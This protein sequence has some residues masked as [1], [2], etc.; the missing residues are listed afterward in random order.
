MS[1]LT[2]CLQTET[3]KALVLPGELVQPPDPVEWA[4]DMFAASLPEADMQSKDVGAGK[5]LAK[6]SYFD[7]QDPASFERFKHRILN[8]LPVHGSLAVIDYC[9]GESVVRDGADWAWQ[10]CREHF[11]AGMGKNHPMGYYLRASLWMSCGDHL[12]DAHCD[13][14]DGFLLHVSGRKRVRVWPVPRKFRRKLVFNHSDFKGRMSTDPVDFELEPGQILFI[15]S[16][17]MHEVIAHGEQPAVSVSFHMGSPF[18]ILTL[19]KQLNMLIKG[20]RIEVPPY[21]R[22]LDKFNIYFFEPSRFAGQAGEGMP[23]EL[24]TQLA[25]VLQ[26]NQVDPAMMRRLLSKWWLLAGS[27]PMYQGPY[28]ER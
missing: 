7:Q 25:G 28:P 15:P 6:P 10:F 26:S 4:L 23:V 1:E 9:A 5:Q 19:C 16:G 20:G 18:P 11:A 22:K 14:A 8:A 17:A 12:Y 24:Q 3:P 21:M 2:D 13:L 27:R